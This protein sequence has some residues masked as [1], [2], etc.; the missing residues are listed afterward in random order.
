ML[1]GGAASSSSQRV[2]AHDDQ[3]V[4][5]KEGD[6]QAQPHKD[7]ETGALCSFFF[8]SFWFVNWMLCYFGC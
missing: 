1:T 5:E 3:L 6:S 2:Q 8:C 7:G 4:R